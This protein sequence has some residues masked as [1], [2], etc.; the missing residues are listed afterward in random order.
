MLFCPS[1]PKLM[2]ATPEDP[3][4][5][6]TAR[7]LTPAFCSARLSPGPKESSPTFAIMLTGYPSFDTATAWFAPL[8][9]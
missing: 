4:T 2:S 9:P 7:T 8:P 6:S 5:I 3:F 1:R